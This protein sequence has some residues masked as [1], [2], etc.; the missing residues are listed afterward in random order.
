[1]FGM[2]RKLFSKTSQRIATKDS[3]TDSLIFHQIPWSIQGRIKHLIIP[4]TD[5]SNVP[6]VTTYLD[7]PLSGLTFQ[8]QT[9]QHINMSISCL[10]LVLRD[11]SQFTLG[12]HSISDFLKRK[13]QVTRVSNC[14]ASNII[15]IALRKP[16]SEMTNGLILS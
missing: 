14:L 15:L 2:E 3:L 7:Q 1:M 12:P 6:N 11:Q 16:A 4:V 5:F 8:V 9:L 13:I 10:T